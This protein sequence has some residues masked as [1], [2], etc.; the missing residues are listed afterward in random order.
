MGQNGGTGVDE[1]REKV[2][3]DENENDL[4]YMYKKK[5][6]IWKESIMCKKLERFYSRF[7]NFT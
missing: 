6:N 2:K 4:L 5:Y 1:F 7:F 3:R